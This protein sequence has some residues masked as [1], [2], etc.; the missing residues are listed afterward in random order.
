[1]GRKPVQKPKSSLADRAKRCSTHEDVVRTMIHR[2]NEVINHRVSWLATLQGLLFTALAFAWDKPQIKSFLILLCGMGVIISLIA[3]V[4]LC[5]TTLAMKR[6]WE[7]WDK[8]RPAGYD[9]PDVIGLR[10]PRLPVL[11]FIA[12]W[13][14]IPVVFAIAWVVV[15]CIRV[16]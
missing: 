15:F 10:P 2:E 14:F 12:P 11:Q 9:G 13:T 16:V 5:S 1:M 4:A 7:W 3:L 6:L 8:N